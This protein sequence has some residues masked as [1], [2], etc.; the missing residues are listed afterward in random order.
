MIFRHSYA[1]LVRFSSYSINHRV[2]P[3]LFLINNHM[4]SLSTAS[5]SSRDESLGKP[6]ESI[7]QHT[8]KDD[9]PEFDAET[10][11][12]NL[13]I[14]HSRVTAASEA[15]VRARAIATTPSTPSSGLVSTKPVRLVAVSKTK[16]AEYIQTLYDHG[17]R[18]F[19]EN[20]F[21]ELVEKAELL[22]KD[23]RWHF[24]GHL[25]SSKSS[26]LVRAVSN[27]AMIETVDSMKLATKLQNACE[28]AGRAALDILIQMDTSNEDT[29]SGVDMHELI[30]LAEEINRTCPALRIKGLMTIGAPGDMSCFDKLASARDVLASAL[31]V[32][33]YTLELSMGMSGDF[34]EAIARGATSVR[35]GST[36][37]GPR[38][39]PNKS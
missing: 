3:S 23:I 26:K 4:D 10:L 13:Q 2:K 19:G 6:A 18:D 39:Y 1:Y 7:I 24:I 30:P 31:G 21:Q 15:A 8:K 28:S 17:H 14:V 27:L 35:V 32:D 33:K 9:T 11:V 5:A 37:F 25:Q 16:P 36:I 22:P 20:Y 12:N 29:K 34:E 38:I